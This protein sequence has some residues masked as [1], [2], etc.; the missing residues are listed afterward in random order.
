MA[1]GEVIINSDVAMS[2]T[3]QDDSDG[4]LSDEASQHSQNNVLAETS[5][6][7]EE[8]NEV[9]MEIVNKH[10]DDEGQLSTDNDDEASNHS[11]QNVTNGK[12]NNGELVGY[13]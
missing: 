4:A 12:D 11:P 2:P 13:F 3:D 10:S 9:T 7:A 8:N 1:E 6:M 5:P